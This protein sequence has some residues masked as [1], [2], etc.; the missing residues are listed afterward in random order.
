MPKVKTEVSLRRELLVLICIGEHQGELGGAVLSLR[1]IAD[2]VGLTA[3]ATR[4]ALNRLARN[5]LVVA[6]HRS[7]PSGASAENSYYLTEEGAQMLAHVKT[8]GAVAS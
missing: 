4:G 7:Y 6:E 8:S 2:Q 1:E 3:A 5:G